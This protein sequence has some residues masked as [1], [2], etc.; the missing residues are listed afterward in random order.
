MHS[1]GW[2]I[3]EALGH[4]FYQLEVM[5]KAIHRRRFDGY[6]MASQI[7]RVSQAD[8]DGFGKF[9]SSLKDSRD[10]V[11]KS[12]EQDEFYVQDVVAVEGFKVG[13]KP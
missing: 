12:E 13:R 8:N 5:S 1:Y 7:S 3:A 6:I 9:I 4:T 10:I 2:T 11:V